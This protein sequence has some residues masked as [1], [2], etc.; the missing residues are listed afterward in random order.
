MHFTKTNGNQ[1]H[2]KTDTA[3]PCKTSQALE[4]ICIQF[5]QYNKYLYTSLI[6]KIPH[7]KIFIFCRCLPVFFQ[8]FGS[9]QYAGRGL[10]EKRKHH[11]R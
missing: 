11:Q 2:C 5:N 3:N 8:P 4:S 7:E 1:P 9:K 6:K 10:S